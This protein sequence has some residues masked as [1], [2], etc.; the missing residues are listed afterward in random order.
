MCVS[1]MNSMINHRIRKMIRM[2]LSVY[3]RLYYTGPYEPLGTVPRAYRR[4]KVHEKMVESKKNIVK[5]KIIRFTQ[6]LKT[7]Y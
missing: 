3:I 1:N 7:A 6:N 5:H 4:R 2:I